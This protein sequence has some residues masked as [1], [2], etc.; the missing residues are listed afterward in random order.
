MDREQL[1]QEA[2]PVILITGFGPFPGV[3]INASSQL[4]RVLGTRCELAFPQFTVI[5]EIMPTEW[6]RAPARVATL[7]EQFRPRLALH[8]GVAKG[9]RGFRI[10]AQAANRCQNA[11]DATGSRPPC[12]T[13]ASDVPVRPVTIDIARI[14]SHL[15]K[16]GH[17]VSI[18]Y[19][20]GGYICN[21]VLFH[22]LA[23]AEGRTCSVGFVHIP[24]DAHRARPG[25]KDP[26]SGA[27]E[28]IKCALL[29]AECSVP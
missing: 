15:N 9:A 1:D 13:L 3:P 14:S 19:D 25:T 6:E 18:S 26:V 20:A 8:F 29:S 27:I 23:A 24:S 11:K 17:Q 28:I 4:V 22:S 12:R 5:T 2:R 7:H 21:A 10:E 16:L